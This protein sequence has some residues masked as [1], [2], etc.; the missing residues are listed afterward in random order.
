MGTHEFAGPRQNLQ[1]QPDSKAPRCDPHPPLLLSQETPI[2]E[3]AEL[4]ANRPRNLAYEPIIISGGDREFHLLN[5]QVLWQAQTQLLRMSGQMIAKMG[6]SRRKQLEFIS[7]E[8]QR[9]ND[10]SKQL[11]LEQ[12]IAKKLDRDRYRQKETAI[13]RHYQELLQLYQELVRESQLV[14]GE[15]HRACHSIF[16]EAHSIYDNS[17]QL[18][19]VVRGITRDWEM[20]TSASTVIGE[21][22]QKVRYLSVQASV[23]NYQSGETSQ[24]VLGQINFEMN[25]LVKQMSDVSQQIQKVASQ[26]KLHVRTLQDMGLQQTQVTR[27]ITLDSRRAE[28]AIAE[29][30][31]LIERQDTQIIELLKKQ[32]T[33]DEPAMQA[34]LNQ[35]MT[36]IE[37]RFQTADRGRQNSGSQHLIELIEKSLK[38]QPHSN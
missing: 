21:I 14:S 5:F 36:Q 23:L 4:V 27:K 37:T 24:T 2:R 25:R 9:L 33:S 35:D 12:K 31:R 18:E 32:S 15:T 34:L 8:K 1:S 38:H 10:F 26:F 7:K 11:Q 29:L 30:D 17:E 13:S 19:A 22:V 16:I 20:M 28:M 3:A 6:Q